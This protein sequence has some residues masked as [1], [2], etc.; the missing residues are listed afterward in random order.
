MLAIGL[1]AG[2]VLLGAIATGGTWAYNQVKLAQKRNREVRLVEV[3]AD[4]STRAQALDLTLVRYQEA[5]QRLAGAA[6]IM[7]EKGD[8]EPL[9]LLTQDRFEPGETAL[10]GLV[11]S[12]FYGKRVSF[13]WLVAARAPDADPEQAAASFGAL[14]ALGMTLPRTMIESLGDQERGLA[15]AAQL[16][17]LANSGAPIRRIVFALENGLS[18]AYPGMAGLA[19]G[20]D[21]RSDPLYQ[22]AKGQQAV[23]WGPPAAEGNQTMILGCAAPIHTR[24]GNLLGVVHFEIDVGRA[25]AAALSAGNEEVALSVLV[26]KTG[27]V[28]AQNAKDPADREPE[29]LANEEVKAAIARGESGYLATQRNGR[30]VLVTY[31]PLASMDWYLVTVADVDK[32]EARP[33]SATPRESSPAREARAKAAAPRAPTT[34][35]PIAKPPE[36]SAST[37]AS[38]APSASAFPSASAPRSASPPRSNATG[39]REG[40]PFD[41]WPIY[42]PK[43]PKAQ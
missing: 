21:A 28:L 24:A 34:V 12:A 38:A 8:V 41:P 43:P 6:G 17:A 42:K 27:K 36:A 33:S 18:A 13:D 20:T 11:D 14:Q 22:Q 1:L 2:T 7:L 32:L 31:Q 26:D 37:S 16:E 23:V 40:N 30:D 15:P 10:A 4:S 5:L 35:A 29:T 39:A 25:I 3:Q 9:E 19:P